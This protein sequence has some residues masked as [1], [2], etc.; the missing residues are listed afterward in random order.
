MTRLLS[1]VVL[2]VTAVAAILVLPLVGIRV[3]GVIVAL[4]AAHEYLKVAAHGSAGT[5]SAPVPLPVLLVV[6]A[7][8]WY[9]LRPGP[10]TVAALVLLA[11]GWLVVDVLFLGLSVPDAAVRFLAPWYIGMPIGMLVSVQGTHGPR[12]ALL[13]LATVVVS[14]SAQYY[15][16]RAFGRR[17]L[18]PV[19]SPKKTIE[20]ALG[21][22]IFGTVFMAMAGPRIL[23][24]TAPAPM[25]AL[26]VV[27][28]VLGICGDLFESRLKRS[29]G[30]KDSSALI[31]GHGG[32]L[33]R[34]D[35]LLF[36]TPAFYLFLR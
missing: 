30:I 29:S 6:A 2:A 22:V 4:L 33:D 10:L 23:P 28:V 13:L 35:A 20:G 11:F 14:D 17:P 32:V 7:T 3:L 21:G 26:G 18:A 12:A 15:T 36:A 25:A 9:M 34:I 16:G 27:I 19:I 5:R 8:C 1:G 24:G 31:P